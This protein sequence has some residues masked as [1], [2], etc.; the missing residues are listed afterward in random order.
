MR[1]RHDPQGAP[2]RTSTLALPSNARG[3]II[4]VV[5]SSNRHLVSR[6]R[7]AAMAGTGRRVC[8]GWLPFFGVGGTAQCFGHDAFAARIGPGFERQNYKGTEVE[9]VGLP[10]GKFKWR[11]QVGCI[12][13]G[14][15]ELIPACGRT[16]RQLENADWKLQR[17]NGGFVGGIAQGQNSQAGATTRPHP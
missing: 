8:T 11:Q 7:S 15:F 16:V 5:S 9:S 3:L 2:R 17:Q 1:F 14:N 4:P 6:H 13:P 10:G 12:A